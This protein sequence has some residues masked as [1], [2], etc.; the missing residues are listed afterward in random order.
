MAKDSSQWLIR[1]A[2]N[3]I[4]GPYSAQQIRE[5]I[6]TEKLNRHDE[7][8]RNNHYWITLHEGDEL[9]EQL[10]TRLPT[11]DDDEITQTEELPIPELDP[12][13][14]E[15]EN[16]EERT[17]LL[18]NRSLR[19]FQPGRATRRKSSTQPRQSAPTEPLHKPSVWTPSVWKW[20]VILL[21][22]LLLGITGTIISRFVTL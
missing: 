12:T 5:F 6:E 19:E 17:L 15:G 14:A 10:Q 18:R 2:E 7:I 4:A 3:M 20:S 21:G 1:T 13:L 8:C 16:I 11:F 9:W 22:L